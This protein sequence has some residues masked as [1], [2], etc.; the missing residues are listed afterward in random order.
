[1]YVVILTVG[2]GVK[3]MPLNI[4]PKKGEEQKEFVSR[5]MANKKM[6]EEFKDQE[7]RAAV[8]YEKWRNRGK[9]SG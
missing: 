2:G 7:Q 1:M 5:C 8:C 3:I 4:E 6:R 9:S